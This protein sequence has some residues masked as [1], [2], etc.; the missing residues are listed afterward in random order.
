MKKLNFIFLVLFAISFSIIYCNSHNAN[1]DADY[2]IQITTSANYSSL[3]DLAKYSFVAG[4]SD[5]NVI[6][7]QAHLFDG[8]N[9]SG[10]S[11]LTYKWIEKSTGNILSNSEFLVL[12]N[13]YN[14]NSGYI[15]TVG[16]KT[17]TIEITGEAINKTADLVVE[18]T[19]NAYGQIIETQISRPLETN[20]NGDYKITKNS[21][22]F[23]INSILCK[24]P[25][26]E[27]INWYYKTPN[28]STFDIYET[29]QKNCKITPA[30]LVSSRNGFGLY[31]FYA[32]A[33]SNAT[34]YTSKIICFETTAE[35]LNDDTTRYVITQKVIGNTKAEL[36][37]FTFTLENAEKDCL[38]FNKILWY[39]NDVKVGVGESFSYEPTSGETFV[40]K[41]QYKG[42]SLTPLAELTTTPKATGTLKLV[43]YVIG[44]VVVLSV[45][46]AISVKIL[47]KKRD[48]VW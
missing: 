4:Y 32:S 45:I 2:K 20:S 1:A 29:N 27:T 19:D 6:T 43:L 31:K 11:N 23:Y 37:A 48:V 18:I 39:I 47:N 16:K 42:A 41:A 40:V 35:S 34:L 30:N 28:S 9:E 36:E 15:I 5:N 17:Y 7:F 14:S 12:T 38:D 22:E 8:E 33:Q 24:T 13:E 10:I 25:S 26:T 3:T 21:T 44:G 46:F